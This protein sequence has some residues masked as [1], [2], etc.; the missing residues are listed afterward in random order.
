MPSTPNDKTWHSYIHQAD[1]HTYNLLVATWW[2]SQPLSGFTAMNLANPTFVTSRRNKPAR[3]G[4]Q[5][6]SG[7]GTGR[8][9]VLPVGSVSAPAYAKNVNFSWLPRGSTTAVTMTVNKLLPA[10]SPDVGLVTP[11]TVYP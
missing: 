10:K 1:G 7:G 4:A 2:A 6:L 11:K 5:D 3:I 8:R 9:I